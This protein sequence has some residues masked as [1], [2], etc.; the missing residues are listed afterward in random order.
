M[1][2]VKGT[3]FWHVVRSAGDE[4]TTGLWSGPSR[5]HAYR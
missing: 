5:R 3:T 4:I 1:T 2:F